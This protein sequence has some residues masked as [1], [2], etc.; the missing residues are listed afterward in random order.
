VLFKQPNGLQKLLFVYV[1]AVALKNITFHAIGVS[2][3][4]LGGNYPAT[5]SSSTPVPVS[6]AAS[7]IE[8]V[9]AT[10]RVATHRRIQGSTARVGSWFLT[11]FVR[12]CDLFQV[13]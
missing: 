10:H 6:T 5:I 2:K 3:E 11:L 13:L 12:L 8:L 4:S 1:L 7:R 9:G